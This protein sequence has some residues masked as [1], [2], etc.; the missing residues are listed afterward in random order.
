MWPQAT[1]GAVWS[2]AN[3]YTIGSTLQTMWI[4]FLKSEVITA[5]MGLCNSN[6]QGPALHNQLGC[7]SSTSRGWTPQNS[8]FTRSPRGSHTQSTFFRLC[9]ICCIK[10]IFNSNVT[11]HIQPDRVGPAECVALRKTDTCIWEHFAAVTHVHITRCVNFQQLIICRQ[12][13]IT[14]ST[15]CLVNITRRWLNPVC[16]AST[17]NNIPIITDWLCLKKISH[18]PPSDYLDVLLQFVHVQAALPLH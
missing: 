9:V 8:S 12:Q 5:A 13:N 18:R 16:T 15:L 7:I 4:V 2:K 10:D 3:P 1:R 17:N 6:H 11:K 14:A